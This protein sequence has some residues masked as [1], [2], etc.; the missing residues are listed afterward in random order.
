MKRNG[1]TPILSLTFYV[2]RITHIVPAKSLFIRELLITVSPLMGAQW[3]QA[4]REEH[5]QKKGQMTAKLVREIM[6][7]AKLG[8]LRTQIQADRPD[9]LLGSQANVIARAASQFE[10]RS[11]RAASQT[12]ELVEDK[13]DFAADIARERDVVIRGPPVDLIELSH[14][15]SKRDLRV[16]TR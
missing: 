1:T 16:K 10:N 9:A 4:G 15:M 14:V 8:H 7:A 13:F 5:A 11:E 3:K 2:S 12:L 6:V